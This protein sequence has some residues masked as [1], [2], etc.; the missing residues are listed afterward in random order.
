MIF[1]QV[2]KIRGDRAMEILTATEIVESMPP[3]QLK[4]LRKAYQATREP[5]AIDGDITM[6]DYDEVLN[7]IQALFPKH[8]YLHINVD[9]DG[10]GGYISVFEEAQKEAYGIK[11]YHRFWYPHEGTT[12]NSC[13]VELIEEVG[14]GQGPISE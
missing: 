5:I 12:L 14:E 3:F 11:S 4:L 9:P 10:G 2:F 8:H 13:I 7:E 6:R 1:K